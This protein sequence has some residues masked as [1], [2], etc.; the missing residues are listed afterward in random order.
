MLPPLLLSTSNN[1]LLILLLFITNK[2]DP[3]FKFCMLLRST[4]LEI[5]LLNKGKK[6]FCKFCWT[7]GGCAK[8]GVGDSKIGSGGGGKI[9]TNS[10]RVSLKPSLSDATTSVDQLSLTR[11][12][13]SSPKQKKQR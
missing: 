10:L 13:V 6:G 2:P 8:G 3:L 4:I 1:T 11:E 12:Y 9:L 5:V 7:E